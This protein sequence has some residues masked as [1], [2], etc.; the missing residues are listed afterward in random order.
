[1][2][3]RKKR[4]FLSTDRWKLHLLTAFW[5]IFVAA[6]LWVAGSRY[7]AQPPSIATDEAA[8]A[9]LC[10]A[11]LPAGEADTALHFRAF[12][13]HFNSARHL[14]NYVCYRLTHRHTTD[15]EQRRR[16][17][18]FSCE[19]VKGC[20]TLADYQQ[21]GY[22]RG[23]MAP[24]ADFLHDSIALAQTYA[25]VNICPQTNALNSGAWRQLE[26][27]VREW[28][29][30]DSLLIVWAGPIFDSHGATIGQTTKM[31]VP[32]HYF[33]VVLAPCGKPASA[34]AFIL[35]NDEPKASLAQYAVSVQEVERRTGIRFF[36]TLPPQ[37]Q[38]RL[39]SATNDNEW[40]HF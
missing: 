29:Q 31:Q 35:P 15:S 1:M 11:Q 10:Q 6:M 22:D 30:R 24:A 2:A 16:L 17:A 39:K 4:K 14:P 26:E 32:S 18:F 19:G 34:I 5:A 25:L 12:T 8:L 33:K 28:V 36:T 21:S 40:F 20:P 23:H 9:A 7:C 3:I 38:Q 27:K 37:E 13:V